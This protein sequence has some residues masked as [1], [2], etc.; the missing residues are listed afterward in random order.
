MY[1][2][3]AKGQGKGRTGPIGLRVKSIF[4]WSPD[5]DIFHIRKTYF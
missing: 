4:F 1:F 5:Y 2:I 3:F